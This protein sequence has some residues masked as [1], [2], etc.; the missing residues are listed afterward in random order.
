[1]TPFQKILVPTDFSV[2]AE[3]ATLLAADLSR[4]YD[5]ELTLLYVHEPPAYELPEG[6]VMNMPS[7]LDRTFAELNQ[8]LA[9]VQQAARAA[10]ATRVDTRL[11]QGPIVREIVTFAGGFDLLVMGTQGRTGLARLVLGSVA[12][13]VVQTAPCPV[14]VV[15]LPK[16]GP[17]AEA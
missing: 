5:A 16:D 12:E 10:G 1:M 9:E 7:Q 3:R 11:L 17:S 8:R 13:R 2:H 15:R 4:R 6:H 14:L